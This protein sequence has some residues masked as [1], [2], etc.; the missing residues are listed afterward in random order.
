MIGLSAL[1]GTDDY[2]LIG[3]PASEPRDGAGIYAEMND[4][5]ILT[6]FCEAPDA[7]WEMI[8]SLFEGEVRMTVST[9]GAIHDPLPVLRSQTDRMIDSYN[10]GGMEFC[11]YFDGSSEMR[12]GD[13][14]NPAASASLDRPGIVSFFTEEKR[15]ELYAILDRAGT[16]LFSRTDAQIAQIVSEELSALYAGACSPEDCAKKIQS[17]VGIWLAEHS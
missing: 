1:F 16:P 4:A 10:A 8:R 14:E 5:V 3:L 13:P 12:R 7:G 9:S 15:Q 17:R 2:V 6:S 11:F